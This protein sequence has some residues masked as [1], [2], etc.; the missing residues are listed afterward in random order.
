MPTPAPFSPTRWTLVLQAGGDTPEARAALGELCEIYY[1]PVLEFIRRWRH[2][3]DADAAS[4]Q[5]HAFFESVLARGQLGDP[6]PER[7]RFRS[8]LLG[9]VKHF[10]YEQGRAAS[11][12]KRGAGAEHQTLDEGLEV[13]V[14]PADDAVFDRAWALTVIGRALDELGSEM[15]AA[16]KGEQF[17]AF[18]PWLDGNAA[19]SQSDAGAALGLSATATKVAVHRLRERLRKKVRAEIAAT[20]ENPADLDAELRHLVSTLSRPA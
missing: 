11:A 4:D 3:G 16:G 14:P 13:G 10:L 15:A 5:A 7:G 6:D 1:A 19:G 2:D 12:A 17:E 18:K 8:Y 9:A 20:L